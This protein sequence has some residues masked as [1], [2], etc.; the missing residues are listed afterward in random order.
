VI[1]HPTLPLTTPE[2]NHVDIDVEI[3]D[4]LERCR[5]LGA[6]TNWSCQN[7]GEAMAVQ[8]WSPTHLIALRQWYLGYAVVDFRAPGD[9]AL[10]LTATARGG[11]RHDFYLR[12]V[13]SMAPNAW[14]TGACLLDLA[15]EVDEANE[16]SVPTEFVMST[17]RVYLPRQ[18][19]AETTD[20][21]RRYLDGYEVPQSSID[22]NLVGW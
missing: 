18:D 7:H 1:E 11:P 15:V 12:M 6:R 10:F 17:G 14:R 3:V 22:W 2:G 13:H 8:A 16:L 20:R 21:L 19:I 5:E 4:L 9:L